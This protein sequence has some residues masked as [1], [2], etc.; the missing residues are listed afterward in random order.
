MSVFHK[1]YLSC[2]LTTEHLLKTLPMLGNW[3]PLDLQAE[4]R[5]RFPSALHRRVA[6]TQVHGFDAGACRILQSASEQRVEAALVTK[7][8]VFSY[9][10]SYFH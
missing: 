6:L 5:R 3:P 9:F 1:G 8:G 2:F 10:Y 4:A 7:P